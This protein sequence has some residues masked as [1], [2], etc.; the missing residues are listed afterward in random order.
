MQKIYTDRNSTGSGHFKSLDEKQHNLIL[1][2]LKSHEKSDYALYDFLEDFEDAS[3]K[4]SD[5]LSINFQARY[6]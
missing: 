6:F 5:S 2:A 4:Y 1:D 3:V